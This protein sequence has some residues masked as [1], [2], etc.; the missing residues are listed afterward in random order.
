MNNKTKIKTNLK[1]AILFFIPL[2][3]IAV[4]L[5]V[6]VFAATSWVTNLALPALSGTLI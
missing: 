4:M 5:A 2:C 3:L 1:R 6:P